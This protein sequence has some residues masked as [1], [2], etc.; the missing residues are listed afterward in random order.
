[1]MK[2]AVNLLSDTVTQPSAAMRAAIAAAPVGDDV[3]GADPTVNELQRVAAAKLGKAAALFVPS[4]DH[5]MLFL[6]VVCTCTLTR[7]VCS[8]TMS[9]LIAIGAHCGRG[10]EII[11]GDKAH[12]FVYEGAGASGAFNVHSVAPTPLIDTV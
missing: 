3:Y 9:N 4:Y 11:L 10:D 7:V 6:L 2:R 12:I 5:S 1:M 8:G